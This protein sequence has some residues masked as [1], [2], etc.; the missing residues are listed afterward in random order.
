M[1]MVASQSFSSKL[2]P[3]NHFGN[4]EYWK[5]PYSTDLNVDMSGC[6]SGPSVY[7]RPGATQAYRSVIEDTSCVDSQNCSMPFQ[8]QKENQL[9]W[10]KICKNE[11]ERKSKI[12]NMKNEDEKN[13]DDIFGSK[14]RKTNIFV[15]QLS[16]E[17]R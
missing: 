2:F 11:V 12:V 13:K 9:V 10:Q 3:H 5:G 17:R 6:N 14:R 7:T 4:L 8:D 16:K 15:P 1:K